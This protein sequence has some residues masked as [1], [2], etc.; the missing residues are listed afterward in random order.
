VGPE[1]VVVVGGRNDGLPYGG[2]ASAHGP[3]DVVAW[4]LGEE[5]GVTFGSVVAVASAA[6]GELVLAGYTDHALWLGR[7]AADGAIAW[8]TTEVEV[9][10]VGHSARDVAMSWEGD[11]LVAGSEGQG[12]GYPLPWL[13]RFAPDGSALSSRAYPWIASGPHELDS[14]QVTDDGRIFVAGI[15]VDDAE[16]EGVWRHAQE[17]A[18]HESIAWEW[19]HVNPSADYDYANGGGLAWS[20][21]VGLVVGGW[22]YLGEDD[23]YRQRGFLARL[24][25]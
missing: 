24:M 19:A 9:G 4:E 5:L 21:R 8:T 18:C 10:D 3:G 7:I 6:D 14:I 1:T 11:I 2:F 22:D 13:G 25:P 20:S 12:S 17:V 23:G 16:V 15:R